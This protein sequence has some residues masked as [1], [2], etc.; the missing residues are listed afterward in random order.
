MGWWETT[1][2]KRC[3]CDV[4][5]QMLPAGKD[6]QAWKAPFSKSGLQQK[7]K[8]CWKKQAG[9][10]K[11]KNKPWLFYQV[12]SK[13]PLLMCFSSAHLSV[14]VWGIWRW[15]RTHSLHYY[16]LL[17]GALFL[18][19]FI[20]PRRQTKHWVSITAIG[21]FWPAVFTLNYYGA[22]SAG[23]ILNECKHHL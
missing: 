14:F 2:S 23:D 11:R 1:R 21:R 22:V 15:S 18:C 6:L 19:H 9:W 5:L 17:N 13:Q 20:C 4:W 7:W 12:V 10:I 3:K 8:V 16:K